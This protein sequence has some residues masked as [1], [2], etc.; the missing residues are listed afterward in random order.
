MGKWHV[1][2]VRGVGVCK[3]NTRQTVFHVEY[4]GSNQNTGFFISP[5]SFFFEAMIL[6]C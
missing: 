5:I 1:E 2:L 4:G 6:L 3:T